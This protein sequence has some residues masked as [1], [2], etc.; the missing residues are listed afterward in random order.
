MERYADKAYYFDRD[1]YDPKNLIDILEFKNE[2]SKTCQNSKTILF[3]GKRV[4]AKDKCSYQKISKLKMWKYLQKNMV[5]GVGLP[6]VLEYY[7]ESS[8]KDKLRNIKILIS[9]ALAA[10]NLL[11]KSE[12]YEIYLSFNPEKNYK[13]INELLDLYKW[14]KQ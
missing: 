3:Q 14:K 4:F 12:C 8:F 11:R 7:L 9:R 6:M 5:V 2:I 1:E 13:K 10:F